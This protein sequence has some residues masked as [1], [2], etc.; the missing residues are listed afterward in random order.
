MQPVATPPARLRRDLGPWCSFLSLAVAVAACGNG[1]PAQGPENA[2]ETTSSTEA[3]GGA[4]DMPASGDSTPTSAGGASASG[5]GGGAGS[6]DAT[7]K[8]SPCGGFDIPDLL[9]VI[10]QAACVVPNATPDEKPRD[11]KDV[12][13]IRVVPDSPRIAPGSASNITVIFKNKGKTE[14][15][16]DFV[17]DPEPRFDF[18]VYTLKGTRV[19][20]PRGEAPPL[21]PEVAN[22]TPPEP[23][24]ARV[25]LAQQGTAKLV[26]QWDAV[27]YKWASRQ[28]ARGALPGRGYPKD[29]AGPL[30]KGTYILRV[31]TPLTGVFEGVDHEISQPRVQITVARMP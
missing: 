26:L 7:K 20:A 31:V 5:G 25:M 11:V 17:V 4:A 29:P 10:S 3:D 15:P 2:G 14:L 8:P 23:Q 28:R 12:L 16:L 22:A 21:P 6:D 27:R 24:I 19:D 13:E 18:A 30:P 9:A 1:K